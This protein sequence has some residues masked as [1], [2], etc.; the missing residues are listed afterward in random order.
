MNCRN[1]LKETCNR[2]WSVHPS[3]IIIDLVQDDIEEILYSDDATPDQINA[4]SYRCDYL[5]EVYNP[6]LKKDIEYLNE[7]SMHL[8]E[9]AR[10]AE[11]VNRALGLDPNK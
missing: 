6:A 2:L 7:L 9:W 10:C 11:F 3:Q 5:L 1:K 8:D 4:L